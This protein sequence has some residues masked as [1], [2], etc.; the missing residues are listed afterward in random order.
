[1]PKVTASIVLFNTPTETIGRLLDCL[2]L[3]GVCNDI[4]IVD[5]SPI[6]I[7]LSSYYGV[8]NL[9]IILNGNVGFGGGHNKVLNMITGTSDFHFILNPDIYF[10]PCMLSVMLD[11]IQRDE[12]VGLLIP[13]ILF[14]NGS[15]QYSCRLLPSPLNLFVRRFNLFFPK[16]IIERINHHY[17]L[18]DTN[19]D[20]EMN[21]PVLSGCFL[22]ARMVTLKKV[23]FFDERFFMYLEDVDLSRRIHSISKT[24][25]FPAAVIYHEHAKSSFQNMKMLAFHISSTIKYFNKWGWFFDKDRVEKNKKFLSLFSQD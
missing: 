25:F 16:S 19:Y 11:R 6:S 24:I 9:H 22:L 13:K 10:E 23:D 3:S 5:Q 1:M 17:E 12:R 2:I 8:K 14:P 7:D 4:F 21:P 20:G 18:R 15:L